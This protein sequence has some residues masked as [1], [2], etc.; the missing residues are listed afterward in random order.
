M[1]YDECFLLPKFTNKLHENI[2]TYA[3]QCMVYD[4]FVHYMNTVSLPKAN[5]VF[6]EIVSNSL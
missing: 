2:W 1:E 3:R 4:I 6:L 5:V